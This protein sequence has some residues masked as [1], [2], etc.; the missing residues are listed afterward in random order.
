[1]ERCEKLQ[2]EDTTMTKRHTPVC[3]ALMALALLST[4]TSAQSVADFYK[5]RTLAIVMGT[6]P[7]GSF[8]LYGRTIAEH[9]SRHIPGNPPIIVE[10]MPGAGG[11]TAGNYIYNTG[12]QDGSKV[13]LS[14]PLPLIE[15]LEPKGVRFESAKFRWLGTY[16]SI[17]QVLALWHTAPAKTIDDLK[18]R[19]LVVGSF[20]K[21]HL[22]YQWAMLT[23]TALATNY[24]VIIG[25]PSGNELN[26][27]MERGE[28]HGWVSAW[29]NLAGT[30]PDWL[31]DKKLNIPVQFTPGRLRDLPDVPTLIELTP[32]DKKDV[33]EFISAG[34]P[35]SRA[36]AVGPGVPMDRVAAL[37]KAFDDLMVD[38]A[39][40]ADAEKRKLDID[41]RNGAQ[42]HAMLEK[43]V[44]A[45]PDLVSR[46]KKA[47]GQEE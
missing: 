5:G 24:K 30:R 37:R 18:S 42:A 1:M 10:H 23:K 13:L 3:A 9:W 45:S 43:I 16:D 47:I 32:P 20:N 26:L 8:D 7:G 44:D 33:V 35:F 31:R 15:K 39:F 22:T 46:A 14:H 6:G 40:L 34:T 21:S 41:P 36:L 11:V 38:K 17:A 27:A 19:D 29:A 12:P 25:Y 4:S 2:G 28:I